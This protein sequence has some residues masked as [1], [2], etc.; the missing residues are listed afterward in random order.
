ME[1]LQPQANHETPPPTTNTD[2]YKKRAAFW[3]TAPGAALVIAAILLF[4][5]RF[6]HTKITDYIIGIASWFLLGFGLLTLF[7]GIAYGIF[8]HHRI[9]KQSSDQHPQV[10]GTHNGPSKGFL[11]VMGVIFGIPLVT[12]VIPL[13]LYLILIIIFGIGGAYSQ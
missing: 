12:L 3:F 2:K 9:A 8:L 4:I 6:V 13:V 10:S 5:N 7:P 1:P 11:I